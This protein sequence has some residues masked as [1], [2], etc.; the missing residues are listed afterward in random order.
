MQTAFDAVC[1]KVSPDAPCAV[2][3]VAAGLDR[4]PWS[5]PAKQWRDRVMFLRKAEGESWPDLSDD[6]LAVQ[7]E[8]WLAAGAVRQDSAEGRF[9]G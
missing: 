6:A 1:Q 8:A 4:L 9:R 7:R 2:G 3:P 5:K